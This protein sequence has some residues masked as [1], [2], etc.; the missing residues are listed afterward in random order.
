MS[1][2]KNATKGKNGRKDIDHGDKET[3]ESEPELSAIEILAKRI[4][5]EAP[6]RGYQSK[7]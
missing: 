4:Q 6:E 3:K 7:A 5:D 1:T 2:N